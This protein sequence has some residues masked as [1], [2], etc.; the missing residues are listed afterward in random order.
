MKTQA[1]FCC[2]LLVAA[3]ACLWP[4]AGAQSTDH[5]FV[6]EAASGGMAEVKLGQL[7][8]QN[9]S[10]KAV[11]EFG[12]RMVADHSKANDQLKEAASRDNINVPA[13][14]SQK[15][16][17]TYERLSKLSG[18]EFDKAYAAT[19]VKDH[20]EDVAAFK[21]EATA[22]T[23]TGIKQFASETLPTLEEHL[24]MAEAMQ[25]TVGVMNES[26]SRTPTSH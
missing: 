23:N 10:S 19:M 22:G 2:G 13:A 17:A 8:E 5:S 3:M 14:M 7:A 11:K 9:G 25:K 24:K 26:S 21:K 16:Q 1:A 6:K 20:R 18:R 12:S 15:D 4:T